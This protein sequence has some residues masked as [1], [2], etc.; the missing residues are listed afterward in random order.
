MTPF[1]Q[2]LRPGSALATPAAGALLGVILCGLPGAL[3][4]QTHDHSNRN[5]T[6]PYAGHENREIAALSSEEIDGL[7][8]GEGV[9]MALPAELNGYPGPKHVLEMAADLNLSSDQR[10][11]VEAVFAE[12]QATAKEQ[13]ARLVA[14]ERELDQAFKD[15]TV[16]GEHLTLLLSSIAGERA[17][18]RATHLSAHLRLVPVLSPE[19]VETYKRIRGYGGTP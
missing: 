15:R 10:S 4:A 7:L 16:T 12:M 2:L 11:R 14:L 19:Q 9:G 17:Q 5:H 6:S 18:L 1:P 8:A 3:A 13:G